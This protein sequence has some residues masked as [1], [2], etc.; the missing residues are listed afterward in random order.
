MDG[1][2]VSSGTDKLYIWVMKRF[3][4][5]LLAAVSLSSTPFLNALADEITSSAGQS[6]RL[7]YNLKIGGLHLADFLATFDEDQT[8]YRTTLSM[9]TRGMARWFQDFEAEVTGDGKIVIESGQGLTLVPRRFDRAWAAEEIAAS[10]RIAYDPLS[11]LARSQERMFNPM[12]GEDLSFEDMDWN[13]DRDPP[14]PV[15]D[16]MRV[17]VL[18]PMAAF[19]AARGQVHHNRQQR[20]RVPIYDGRRRYDLVGEVEPMR[21]FWI[22][23]EDVDLVPVVARVDPVFGFDRERTETMQ[24][25][26]GTL[27][28]SSDGRFIPVQVILE[29]N[30]FTSVM[31]LT[32]DCRVDS[33][34]CQEIENSD[35]Q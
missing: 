16:D 29:G 26:A 3:F 8:G 13:R 14:P 10:L 23:G 12:T 11:G 19:V 6:E 31:N 18:D 17:G 1:L 33:E 4:L 9:K 35:V 27:L 28:F 21:S 7:A 25:S 22:G 30:T 24:D 20:F 34:T 2:A 15:P 5:S 32:A